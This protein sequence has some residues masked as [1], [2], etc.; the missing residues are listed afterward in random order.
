VILGGTKGTIR[1]QKGDGS[2]F[3]PALV[4]LE[5]M[6]RH[7]DPKCSGLRTIRDGLANSSI[8][9]P[10]ILANKQSFWLE[11]L[12]NGPTIRCEELANNARD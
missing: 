12:A 2:P 5:S 6:I 11:V 8:P 7:H 9:Q 4:A 1:G 3:H 10:T